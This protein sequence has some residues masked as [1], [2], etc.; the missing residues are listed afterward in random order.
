MVLVVNS[1][2]INFYMQIH[3]PIKMTSSLYFHPGSAYHFDS[4]M[5]LNYELFKI[6]NS[7]ELFLLLS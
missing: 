1:L 7:E 5:E 6:E 4:D 2:Y 3:M